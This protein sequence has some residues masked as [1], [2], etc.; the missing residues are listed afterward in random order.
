VLGQSAKARRKRVTEAFSWPCLTSA[1]G[2]PVVN[3][4]QLRWLRIDSGATAIFALGCFVLIS[5][6]LGA[7]DGFKHSFRL[8]ALSFFLVALIAVP[9]EFLVIIS[10]V[11][12]SWTPMPWVIAGFGACG[13]ASARWLY[14]KGVVADPQL[15]RRGAANIAFLA[16][17]MTAFCETFLDNPDL[18]YKGLAVTVSIAAAIGSI[19]KAR[20]NRRVRKRSAS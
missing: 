5:V 4:E 12:K 18:T 10:T 20:Q 9:A 17:V 3:T 1:R 7:K 11:G 6:G 2:R 19:S 15:R 13:V 16:F 8:A 14:R